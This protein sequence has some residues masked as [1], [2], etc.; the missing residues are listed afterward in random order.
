MKTL[1]IAVI[2]LAL[3]GCSEPPSVEQLTQNGSLYEKTLDKCKAMTVND[4][5]GSQECR[6]V[7]I[8]AENKM[9][10]ALKKMRM[11]AMIETAK[12]DVQHYSLSAEVYFADHYKYPE[13]V[14]V[15]VYDAAGGYTNNKFPVIYGS[16]DKNSYFMSVSS[17]DGTVCFQRTQDSEIEEC[18]K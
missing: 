15:L 12:A 10:E 9:K 4:R 5:N 16:E 2:A 13:N 11:D 14:A 17:K 7:E 1:I 18:A 6:N 3:A 8:V